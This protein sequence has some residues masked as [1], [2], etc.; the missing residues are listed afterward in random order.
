[1]L[2]H[3]SKYVVV[4][5]WLLRR[6]AIWLYQERRHRMSQNGE[7]HGHW[8]RSTS[9]TFVA[10]WTRRTHEASISIRWEELHWVVRMNNVVRLA[11]RTMTNGRYGSGESEGIRIEVSMSVLVRF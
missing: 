4:L 7:V 6:R 2:W 11:L 1:M 8:H 10:T 9:L 5:H 3:W